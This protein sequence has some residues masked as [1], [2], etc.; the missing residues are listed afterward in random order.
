MVGDQ[1]WACPRLVDIGL[2]GFWCCRSVVGVLHFELDWADL[3]DGGV[4]ASAVVAVFDPGS[5]S[6]SGTCF[7]GPDTGVVELG[8]QRREER[9]SY[10]VIPTDSGV[11][12]RPGD[13]VLGCVSGDLV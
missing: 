11:A 2:G 9:F 4:S 8:L 1:T 13:A 3:A 6:E 12:D 5:D 7:G 10:R